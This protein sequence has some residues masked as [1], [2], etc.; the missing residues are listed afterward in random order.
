MCGVI[1]DDIDDLTG[2]KVRFH[3][4]KI[5][6]KNLCGEEQLSNLHVLCS[7]CYR[8][9]KELQKERRSYNCLSS[10]IGGAGQDAQRIVLEA[11]LMKFE[12]ER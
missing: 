4:G 9:T 7:S 1:A 8:G 10:Q 11:L 12:D 5:K 6:A 2:R 3:I